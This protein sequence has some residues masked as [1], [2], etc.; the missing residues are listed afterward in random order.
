MPYNKQSTL[1]LPFLNFQKVDTEINSDNVPNPPSAARK[2]RSLRSF[3]HLDEL[4]TIA[5]TLTTMIRE[6][7]N[8]IYKR[9]ASIC[10]DLTSTCRKMAFNPGKFIKKVT[11]KSWRT[12]EMATY[13]MYHGSLT[14]PGML[15]TLVNCNIMFY[16]NQLF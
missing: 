16:F 12:N 3:D 13:F 8:G 15:F 1:M 5:N 6:K 9:S 10:N 7:A 4:D 2:K 11:N 14:T